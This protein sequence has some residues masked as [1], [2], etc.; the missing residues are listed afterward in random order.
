[1]DFFMV[2]FTHHSL[3]LLNVERSNSCF[4]YVLACGRTFTVDTKSCSTV[5]R[6]LKL[7]Q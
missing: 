1:M 6:S 5:A 4:M 2:S 3:T 7:P